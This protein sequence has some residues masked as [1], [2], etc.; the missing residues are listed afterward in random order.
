N[1]LRVQ[2]EHADRDELV[3]GEHDLYP[4]LERRLDDDVDRGRLDLDQVDVRVA[5]AGH[6]LAQ[7][8]A[9]G[10]VPGDEHDLC[11]ELVAQVPLEGR[12]R[13]GGRRREEG[14]PPAQNRR[15][16]ARPQLAPA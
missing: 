13:V 9:A 3:V 11:T 5:R 14:D 7:G 16:R 4:A 6:I 15:G 1:Q 10:E 8:L 2:V 12:V